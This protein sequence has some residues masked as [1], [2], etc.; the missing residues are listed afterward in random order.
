MGDCADAFPEGIGT[1]GG[2]QG[3]RQSVPLSNGPGQVTL[4]DVLSG[5]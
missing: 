3:G 1:W 2:N 5:F 4:M